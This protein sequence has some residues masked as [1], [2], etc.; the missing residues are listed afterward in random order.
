[1]PTREELIAWVKV[2]ATKNYYEILRVSSKTSPEDMKKAFHRFALLCHPDQF[3]DQPKEMQE[4]AAEVFKRGVEAYRVLGD[5]KLRER[6]DRAL[7]R[8][9]LR[10]D[11]KSVSERPAAPKVRTLEDMARTTRGKQFAVKADRMLLIGKIDEARVA[12]VSAL[13]EEPDNAELGAKLRH[14]YTL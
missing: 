1:M 6:Y 3:S 8:G 7:K 2:A 9:K 5:A 4:A 10:L 14:I 12:L 11:E 13:Q